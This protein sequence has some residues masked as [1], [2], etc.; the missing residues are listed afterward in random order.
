M[1]FTSTSMVNAVTVGV[2]S[3]RGGGSLETRAIGATDSIGWMRENHDWLG[4]NSICARKVV[5]KSVKTIAI[6]FLA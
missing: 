1:F 2:D 5:Q 3:D 4:L 6:L